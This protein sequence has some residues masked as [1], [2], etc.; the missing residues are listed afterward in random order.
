MTIHLARGQDL[1]CLAILRAAGL[2]SD[3]QFDAHSRLLFKQLRIDCIEIT[4]KVIIQPISVANV[5]LGCMMAV[6]CDQ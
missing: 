2:T 5:L 1:F 6:Y 3:A 4:A